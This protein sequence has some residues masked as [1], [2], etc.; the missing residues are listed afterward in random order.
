MNALHVSSDENNN[1]L[2]ISYYGDVDATVLVG[3]PYAMH[4]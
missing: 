2:G 3:S 4:G 1:S